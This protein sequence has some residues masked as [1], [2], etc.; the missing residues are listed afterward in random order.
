[1]IIWYLNFIGGKYIIDNLSGI[2]KYRNIFAC[3][4]IHDRLLLFYPIET[5]IIK[6]KQ[7]K[8]NKL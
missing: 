3:E 4:S 1:M 2:Q 6:Y 7:N 8:T 5:L